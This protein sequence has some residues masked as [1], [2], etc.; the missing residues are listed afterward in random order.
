MWR[1]C[2]YRCSGSPVCKRKDYKTSVGKI[3][4]LYLRHIF[5]RPESEF[6]CSKMSMFIFICRHSWCSHNWYM[7]LITT[8]SS[9][10]HFWKP[11]RN[12][13]PLILHIFRLYICGKNKDISTQNNSIWLGMGNSKWINDRFK[14]KCL[15]A[16]VILWKKMKL[17]GLFAVI[18]KYLHQINWVRISVSQSNEHSGSHSISSIAPYDGF[19]M[20]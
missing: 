20:S 3:L 1:H 16:G 10:T 5:Y 7:N 13:T 9:E 2:E 19:L 18:W 14:T 11:R 4:P 8:G 15:R 17:T 6:V 12:R